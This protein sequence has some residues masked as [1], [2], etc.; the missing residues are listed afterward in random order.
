MTGKK[1]RSLKID[2]D[3]PATPKNRFFQNGQNGPEKDGT[4]LHREAEA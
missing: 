3:H 1:I 4:R 2:L